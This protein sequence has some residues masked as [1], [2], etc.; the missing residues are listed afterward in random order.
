VAC[1]Q[2]GVEWPQSYWTMV[3]DGWETPLSFPAAGWSYQARAMQ[4]QPTA[5]MTAGGLVN[6]LI[7]QEFLDPEQKPPTQRTSL[8]RTSNRPCRWLGQN[9]HAA[10]WWWAYRV[11]DVQRAARRRGR[12]ATFAFDNFEWYTHGADSLVAKPGR[13]GGW[14]DITNTAFGLAFLSLSRAPVVMNKLQYE[15]PTGKSKFG[16]WQQRPR[17]RRQTSPAGSKSNCTSA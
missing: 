8:T 12:V 17:R 9:A 11:H 6:L 13:D 16:N 4:Q 15:D 1:A 14:G 2:V 7:T 5:S 10:R 3:D